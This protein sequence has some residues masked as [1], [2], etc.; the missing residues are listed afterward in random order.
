MNLSH[1]VEGADDVHRQLCLH[2]GGR[3]RTLVVPRLRGAALA[4]ARSVFGGALILVRRLPACRGRCDRLAER[5]NHRAIEAAVIG[6]IEI[7]DVA[8]Q[9]PAFV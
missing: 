8:Q 5:E 9:H 1:R 4:L 3:D 7:D 2:R 6:C